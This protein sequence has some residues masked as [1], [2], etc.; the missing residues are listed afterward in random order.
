MTQLR[1]IRP[2]YVITN[3]RLVGD[4]TRNLLIYRDVPVLITSTMSPNIKAVHQ[5]TDKVL[6]DWPLYIYK[7][8]WTR[9]INGIKTHRSPLLPE[10]D[11]SCRATMPAALDK[12]LLEEYLLMT[13]LDVSWVKKAHCGDFLNWSHIKYFKLLRLNPN[14]I[15]EYL[16]HVHKKE[17]FKTIELINYHKGNNQTQYSWSWTRAP[18]QTP[19][20]L[21]VAWWRIW[22]HES[23]SLSAQVMAWCL[24]QCWVII[25]EVRYWHSSYGN[26]SRDTPLPAITE[27]SLKIT[28]LKHYSNI[29]VTNELMWITWSCLWDTCITLPSISYS[30]LWLEHDMHV[31]LIYRDLEKMAS[32]L[33]MTL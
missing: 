24:N 6:L 26:F 30:V 22:R 8:A 27:I 2:E 20:W 18:G 11:K 12:F 21:I 25:C 9:N 31:Y 15:S 16:I 5:D 33:Q 29:P 28:Y 19:Y 3:K 14:I 13:S 32:I 1:G 10:V 23:V 7:E 4:A 17:Q